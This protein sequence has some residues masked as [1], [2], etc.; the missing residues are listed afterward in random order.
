MISLAGCGED[1]RSPGAEDTRAF[2]VALTATL[3]SKLKPDDLL[4][5]DLFGTAVDIDENTAVIGSSRRGAFVFVRDAAGWQQQARLT[6]ADLWPGQSFGEHVALSGDVAMVARWEPNE[7]Y[8]FAR[9]GTTWS[10][11]AK[12]TASDGMTGDHFGTA[13]S[14]SGTTAIVGAPGHS[15]ERGAVYVFTLQGATWVEQA[16]LTAIDGEPLDWFGATASIEGDQALVGAWGHDHYA[17]EAYVF[18]RN[19]TSWSQEAK[20]TADEQVPYDA[21][22]SG[23][24]IEGNTAVVG[25]ACTQGNS[26][27]V[28]AVYI[29]IRTNSGWTKQAV[30]KATDVAPFDHFGKSLSLSGDTLLVGA[31]GKQHWLG[32]AYIFSRDNGAWSEQTKL[33]AEDGVEGDEFGQAVG[34]SGDKIVCTADWQADKTGAAYAYL[35]AER[36]LGQK[37]S[38]FAQC[39]SGFCVDGV[40]C[41]DACGEGSAADCQAC[42]KSAGGLSDGTCTPVSCVPSDACHE[43]GTCDPGSGLV[44]QSSPG[45]RHRVR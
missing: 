21:F 41:G 14:I 29:F 24:A 38:T 25:Q 13:L 19:G 10:E 8:V 23:V 34:I 3:D 5:G 27:C 40:C 44:H 39:S 26:G 17:G 15:N 28:G 18:V 22:G 11:Q 30:L 35:L 31:Y 9:S 4:K 1:G 2:A 37:C 6:P 12:L 20:L 7:A 42:S 36:A 33:T 32:A 43:A 45:R 16:K